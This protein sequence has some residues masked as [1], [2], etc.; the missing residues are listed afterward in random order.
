MTILI[1]YKNKIMELKRKLDEK[2]AAFKEEKESLI[3][4]KLFI[5]KYRIMAVRELV[6]TSFYPRKWVYPRFGFE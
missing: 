1:L 3:K 2:N 6:V 5:K 4:G